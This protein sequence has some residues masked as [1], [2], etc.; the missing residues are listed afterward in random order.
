[1]MARPPLPLWLQDNLTLRLQD[2]LLSLP[3]SSNNSD[4]KNSSL[5]TTYNLISKRHVISSL[6]IPLLRHM[7]LKKEMS[8]RSKQNA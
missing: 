8:M 7:R 5:T 6:V 2:G 4:D 3:T 1:M